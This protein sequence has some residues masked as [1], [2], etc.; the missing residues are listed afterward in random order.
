MT[1]S[2]VQMNRA[3]CWVLRPVPARSVPH[4]DQPCAIVAEV[5]AD[6]A[7]EKWVQSERGESE[8]DVGRD[9]TA[10]DLE[11][12]DQER[13]RHPIQLLGEQRLREPSGEPHQVVH[14]DGTGDG[15]AHGLRVTARR[16]P[17]LPSRR[18]RASTPRIRATSETSRH[19]FLDE[20]GWLGAPAR[21]RSRRVGES[22]SQ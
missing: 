15:D 22:K 11:I 13:Q 3:V 7:H 6:R 1:E 9:S 20:G 21:L 4:A 16:V 17:S 10:A 19:Q 8:A 14:G 12:L 2:V 18:I 5:L